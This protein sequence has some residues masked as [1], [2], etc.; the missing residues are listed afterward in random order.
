VTISGA[1]AAFVVISPRNPLWA[2]GAGGVAAI[3]ALHTGLLQVG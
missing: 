1:T 3:A 2:M